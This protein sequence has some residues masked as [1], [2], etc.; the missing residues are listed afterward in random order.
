M[1]SLRPAETVVE[2]SQDFE[3]EEN[4]EEE[5][6]P[7]IEEK[8][9]AKKYM[10]RF[11][12]PEELE[13]HAFRLAQEKNEL[14]NKLKSM[15]Q[16]EEPENDIDPDV[17]NSFETAYNRK[18][19]ALLD[20]AIEEYGDKDNIPKARLRRIQEEAQ[21]YAQSKGDL[22]FLAKK[23]REVETSSKVA[24]DED[25]LAVKQLIDANPKLKKRAEKDPSVWEIGKEMLRAAGAIRGNQ[26]VVEKM[27][28]PVAPKEVYPSATSQTR[29]NS[30][31]APSK[32]VPDNIKSMILKM[33]GS[34]K[35]L[36]YWRNER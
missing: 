30:A 27:E 14:E 21:D 34:Y 20:D 13:R 31:P 19:Q 2:E 24:T 7:A 25:Y 26:P 12:D 22:T 18:S 5:S 32:S 15:A 4:L 28:K 9:P 16:V 1:D 11:E 23:L 36:N 17:K 35:T 33:G 29:K 8:K 10:G 3:H 6:Q